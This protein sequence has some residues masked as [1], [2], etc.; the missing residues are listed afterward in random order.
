MMYFS[1]AD[2]LG[3]SLLPGTLIKFGTILPSSA[4]M[5]SESRTV[6]VRVLDVSMDLPG[7]AFLVKS[8]WKDRR[9]LL[10]RD[11]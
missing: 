1:A 10:V 6:G 2:F 9:L 3:N 11:P 7:V 8:C 5:S 4:A